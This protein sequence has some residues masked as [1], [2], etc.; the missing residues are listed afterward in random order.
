MANGGD[1]VSTGRDPELAGDDDGLV[2]EVRRGNTHAYGVLWARHRPVALR[3][4]RRVDPQGDPEDPVSEAFTNVYVILRAG[5]P[6]TAFRPYLAT[7][8]Q[9]AAIKHARARAPLQLTADF[10]EL[11]GETE[12]LDAIDRLA[13]RD[14][15]A[16]LAPHHREIL[17]L[18]IIHGYDLRTTASH[19]RIS[20]NAAAIRAMRARNQFRDLWQQLSHSEPVTPE[21]Q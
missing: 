17:A 15:L 3:I 20:Y 7:A 14:T 16:A 12:R 11:I 4:A 5:T 9:R 13:V 6:V 10:S 8:V 2:A 18:T 21:R 19:L 1:M